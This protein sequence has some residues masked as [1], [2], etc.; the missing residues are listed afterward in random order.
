MTSQIDILTW[1][2]KTLPSAIAAQKFDFD[3]KNR[4]RKNATQLLPCLVR[5]DSQ[6]P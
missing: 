2:S 4:D 5:F 3:I 1:A 6:D